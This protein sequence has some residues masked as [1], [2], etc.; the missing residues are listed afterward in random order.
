MPKGVLANSIDF[1]VNITNYVEDGSETTDTLFVNLSQTTNGVNCGI[2]NRREPDRFVPTQTNHDGDGDR[3]YLANV[4]L[5][6]SAHVDKFIFWARNE[7]C[8]AD[9]HDSSDGRFS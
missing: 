9:L 7:V 8:C 3:Q 2:P 1:G 4:G 6:I 5:R